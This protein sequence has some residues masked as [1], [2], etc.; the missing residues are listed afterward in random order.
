MMRSY[1]CR[2]RNGTHC[3][4]PRHAT[5]SATPNTAP[6]PWTH[7]FCTHSQCVNAITLRAT[8]SM[9]ANAQSPVYYMCT[10]NNQQALPLPPPYRYVPPHGSA[11]L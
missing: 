8:L 3:C 10:C 5:S 7:A 4:L 11:F 9:R 6:R 1:A 2:R